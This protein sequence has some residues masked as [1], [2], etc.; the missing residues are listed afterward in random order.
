MIFGR[1]Q[2]TVFA[3]SLFSSISASRQHIHRK[4][5]VKQS[6]CTTSRQQHGGKPLKE[7][8]HL[9]YLV[10]C[11]LHRCVENGRKRKDFWEE[12]KKPTRF[13]FSQFAIVC[14]CFSA[15]S[16][17]TDTTWHVCCPLLS[18]K[19]YFIALNAL[20][21]VLFCL[22]FSCCFFFHYQ[23]LVKD[24]TKCLCACSK[25]I[26]SS[27]VSRSMNCQTNVKNIYTK[28]H[29]SICEIGVC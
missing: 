16:D 10:S 12:K 5:C 15:P 27:V 3:I 13:F 6:L 7:T 26:A 28:M 14:T 25:P 29:V 2:Y 1:A 24:N 18:N 21:M 23:P 17:C 11:Y 8:N 20:E 19:K 9:W 22:L 4:Q